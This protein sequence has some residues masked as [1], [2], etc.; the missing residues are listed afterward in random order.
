MKKR[1]I[2]WSIVALTLGVLSASAQA[3]TDAYR[4]VKEGA[5]GTARSQSLGGAMGAVGA[6][7][8]A[9]YINPAGAGLFQRNTITFGFDL[10]NWKTTTEGTDGVEKRQKFLGNFNHA[11]IFFPLVST[12][13]GSSG[14]FKMIMGISAGKDYDYARNYSLLSGALPGGITDFMSFRAIN[15]GIEA[16]EYYRDSDYDPMMQPLD[17]VVV[18]GM[19]GEFILPAVDEG[20]DPLKSKDFVSNMYVL[21]DN[22]D[23]DFLLPVS[24]DLHVNEKGGRHSTDLLLAGSFSDLFYLG[25]SL[26]IGGSYF[27]RNSMYRE[28][29]DNEAYL[30][31]GN[32]ISTKGSSVGVN[33]GAIVAL[34]DF[35]RLGV[36]Y[37]TPQYAQYEERYRS[38]T[39]LFHPDFDPEANQID[40]DSQEYRSSYA[41]MMPGKLTL[42]AMAFIGRFGFVTYDYQY[43]NIG[44]A[45][46]YAPNTFDETFESGFI[47]EDY[48]QENTHR[49]GIEIR[50]A[51]WLSL[52]GGMSYT[53]SPIKV[54][55]LLANPLDQELAY[56]VPTSGTIT[57]FSIPRSYSTY[58]AGVGFNLGSGI[59]L[60]MAYVQSNRKQSVYPF[61]GYNFSAKDQWGGDVDYNLSARGGKLSEVRNS[62]V[63]TLVFRY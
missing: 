19:N 47:K 58:S 62:F 56:E 27:S 5:S 14:Y 22:G 16:G 8:T 57:D 59:S 11:S 35:G 10:G 13:S 25:A 29:F 6:D 52:R 12:S 20:M 34:G 40:F 24:S 41:M 1:Y 2:F 4:N 44:N 43:R 18:M 36:S 38:T 28:D 21:Y 9:A 3:P 50:P 39:R 17:P 42:S 61:S 48:G 51:S 33:L 49:L 32:S 23:A 53:D 45:K 54:S 37:L 46:L 30:E 63:A 60:D 15:A 31:Y 7:A 55:E 26:R